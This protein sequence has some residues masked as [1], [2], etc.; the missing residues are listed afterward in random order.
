MK[1]LLTLMAAASLAASSLLP[2]QAAG[3]QDI[4]LY[5][6]QPLSSWHVTV[7][8][9]ESPEQV[10]QGNELTLPKPADSYAPNGY[11]RARAG[12]VDG[13]AGALT[14]SWRDAWNAGLRLD[15]GA[16]LDLRPYLKQGTLE[17]DINVADLSDGGLYVTMRCG[18]ECSR[19]VSYVL[20]GRALQG[21]GWQ[22]VSFALSC[23]ARDG[24]D[25]SKVP[26]PFVLEGN[27]AGV[28]SVADVK[29]VRRGHANAQCPDYRTVAVTPAMLTHAW[30]LGHWQAR[31]RQKLD[32]LRKLKEAG[33][34]PQVVFIG[35]SITE[36]WEKSGLP[37]W[38]QYYERYDALDLG[39]GGDHTENVL[40]RL[41]HG[42][43]DGIAPK[44][45]V[46]MIGTN[47]A[48]FREEA[49]E[50]TAAG[51]KAVLDELHRRLPHTK[52]LLLAIFPRD[53]QPSGLLRRINARTS[54]LIARFAD[55][56]R[57][58]F[59]DLNAAFLDANGTLS[60]DVMPDLLHPGEKGYGIWARSMEPTLTKLL[61]E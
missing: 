51:V 57:V 33:K 19:K 18:P 55:G 37:V 20:P 28:V 2:A 49:P 59:A 38:K 5:A 15:G 16:P 54:S 11:V 6:G 27:S 40:W 47:N 46:L 34:N 9:F 52:V 21:K 25:F 35:D 32:E 24:D 45:A 3:Q 58:Y 41:Q 50:R 22:H 23:F 39:F 60:R 26:A 36:G 4:P 10:L 14:L 31:H 42:E 56:K 48:G 17:F 12:E 44:V 8:G 61:S 7:S 1:K 43:V 30:S 13:R 53:E 29:L